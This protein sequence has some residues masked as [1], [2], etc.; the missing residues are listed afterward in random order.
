MLSRIISIIVMA[1]FLVTGCAQNKKTELESENVETIENI[2]QLSNFGF[3]AP[4]LMEMTG[5]NAKLPEISAAIFQPLRS[6]PW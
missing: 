3:S 1:G 5:L 6:D 4:G 2:Q